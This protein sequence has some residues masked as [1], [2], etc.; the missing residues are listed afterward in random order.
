M[1]IATTDLHLRLSIKTGTAGNQAAQPSP[2]A[3]LGKYISTTDLVDATLN[4][5]FD[6]V[7]GDEN[8]A[9]VVDYRCVFAYNGHATLTWLGVVV[10]VS[11]E[12]A[13]GANAA[14]AIDN[15]TASAIG[16]S[17]AQADQIATETT[18]PTGVGAFST[19][20]SKAA[21]LVLGD[22]PPG[23]CRA[24]WVRRT[25]TNSVALNNDGATFSVSGDT[26]A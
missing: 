8:A 25:A 23:Q 11:A 12:V 4:N 26:A 1:P 19:P 10:W 7:T 9:G 22:I 6:D 17:A 16:S 2:N 20:T 5:L 13:G 15:I 18:A 21:G 24:F 14:V 3:S